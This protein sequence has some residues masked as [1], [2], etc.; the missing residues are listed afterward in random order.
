MN[1]ITQRFRIHTFGIPHL[2]TNM[3]Y[4][5]CAYT[6]KQIKFCRM[7]QSRGHEVI[8]YGH[9][10]SEV[11]ASEFVPV[12]DDAVLDQAYHGYDW[13]RNQFKHNITDHAYQ[14]F[15]RRLQPELLSRVRNGDFVHCPFGVAHEGPARAAEALGARV[16]E[17]GIG[18]TSG[19]FARWRAY[20]SHAVRNYVERKNPQDWY[21]RVIPN[22]F[23][24]EEFKYQEQKEPWVLY[25]GRIT[26]LKGITTCIRATAAAGVQLKIAGQGNLAELGY[27]S[28]PDHVEFLGYADAE[29]RK[30]LMARAS[31]LIVASTYL[32][33]FGGVQV[34][35]LLSGT[36][37]IT[38]GFGAF[39]E[40]NLDERTGFHCWTLRDFRDAVLRRGEIDPA[41]CRA[42][43]LE[44][45][46]DRVAPQFERWF[47]DIDEVYTGQ[48]WSQL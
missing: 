19:H 5:S 33:P 2:P 24:P 17:G 45:S 28:L 25:L 38:P 34:E 1:D 6:T 43:G 37:V 35:A 11:L 30:D 22:Y 3:T 36:P 26:E 13:R 12:T 21:S 40:V 9:E 29:T 47:R 4:N 20:E 42:R 46:L 41:A 10:H 44:Y 15:R 39:A 16:V 7:M 23:D 31:A 8:F 27:S 14:E 18:Y 48:G 32:E